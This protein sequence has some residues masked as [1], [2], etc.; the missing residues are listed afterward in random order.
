MLV[1]GSTHAGEEEPC[2]EAYMQLKERVPGLALLIA[3][4]EV[5]R[6]GAVARLAQERGL[7]AARLSQGPA[8]AGSQVVVL[9][10]LGKLA[11]AYALGAASFVGGLPGV[12][13]RAQSFGA[14]RPRGCRWCSAPSPTTFWKWPATWKR[15]AAA[16]A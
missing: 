10:L 9:D 8:P 6:G 15:R 3:P 16:C 4:R 12:R 1:A 5:E 14:R 11:S 2:L 13:G 7:S